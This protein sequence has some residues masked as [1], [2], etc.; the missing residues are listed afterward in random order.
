MWDHLSLLLVV[1]PLIAAPLAAIL[2]FGRV[3][4]ALSFFVALACAVMAGMQLWTVLTGGPMQYELGGWSPPWGIAY[5]I[6][7]VNA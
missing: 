2:P 6:D 7:E 5:R 1:V 4:W 3:P